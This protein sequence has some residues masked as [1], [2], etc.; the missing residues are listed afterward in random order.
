M[1]PQTILVVDD[2]KLVLGFHER[3]LKMAGFETRTTSHAEKA[4]E[5]LLDG[6]I[7]AVMTDINMPGLDGKEFIK[8]IRQHPEFADIPILVISTERSDKTRIDSL[9]AG[10]NLFLRKPIEPEEIIK[11]LRILLNLEGD[12]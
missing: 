10:A 1:N 7:S 2:S 8:K 9:A 11:S 3:I 4:L 6:G 12:A 5:W